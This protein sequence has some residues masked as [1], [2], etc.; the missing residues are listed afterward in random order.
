ME[1][2]KPGGARPSKNVRCALL[3]IPFGS[4]HVD[5]RRVTSGDLAS[6][7]AGACRSCPELGCY[8]L[9]G[10]PCE[11]DGLQLVVDPGS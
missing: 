5:R 9:Q 8:G 1:R 11:L 4:E 2:S 6:V 7:P 3:L 10:R